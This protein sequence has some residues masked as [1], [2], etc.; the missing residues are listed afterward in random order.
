MARRVVAFLWV[1][2][3]CRSRPAQPS[4]TSATTAATTKRSSSHGTGGLGHSSRVPTTGRMIQTTSPLSPVPRPPRVRPWAIPGSAVPNTGPSSNPGTA[5]PGQTIPSPNSGPTSA[6]SGIS[7]TSDD[8]CVAVGYGSL[9]STVAQ[10]LVESWNGTSWSIV[11]SPDVGT[12]GNFLNAVSCVSASSCTAV[13]QYATSGGFPELTLIESW[14]GTKWSIVPS[15]NRNPK[16]SNSLHAV[17]C[18]AARS[19]VAVGEYPNKKNLASTLIES[20]NGAAW[21]IT[22]SPNTAKKN[23]LYGVSCT[24]IS[25]CQAVGQGVDTTLVESW[26]GAKW[27]QSASPGRGQSSDLAGVSCV[28][29]AWCGAVGFSGSSR[30]LKTLSELYG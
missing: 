5:Q 21:S 22:S 10:T 26:N 9:S 16:E 17:S 19:C 30:T 1:T 8:S 25:R 4:V 15:P 6:L 27:T 18:A 13:G 20:W 23:Y 12:N 11:P 28:T 2:R 3:V 24:S 7:C 14:D 29:A